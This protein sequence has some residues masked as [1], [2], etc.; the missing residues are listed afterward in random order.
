MGLKKSDDH[1]LRHWLGNILH[2]RA[3]KQ[4]T[5]SIKQFITELR[6]ISDEDMGRR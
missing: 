2:N 1:M 5:K 3:V 4:T 6:A